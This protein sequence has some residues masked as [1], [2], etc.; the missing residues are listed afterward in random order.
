MESEAG[1]GSTFFFTLPVQSAAE[2][3]VAGAEPLDQNGYKL[4]I[5][6]DLVR[7]ALEATAIFGANEAQDYA[8]TRDA[9]RL[10]DISPDLRKAL[11]AP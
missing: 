11:S 10:A 5:L 4:A 8:R 7:Q 2:A 3:V 1:K 9:L 6:K